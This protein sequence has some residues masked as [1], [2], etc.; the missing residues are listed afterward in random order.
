M[1]L[2][3]SSLL[4]KL[5]YLYHVLVFGGCETDLC[6]FLCDCVF[7]LSS[8]TFMLML[9]LFV[10]LLCVFGLWV[11]MFPFCVVF[12]LTLLLLFFPGNVSSLSELPY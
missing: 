5:S 11:Y 2:L 8:V 9:A 1:N 12:R 7:G 4:W 6:M 10:I 3:F